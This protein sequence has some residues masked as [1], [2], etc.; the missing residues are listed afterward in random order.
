MQVNICSA[1]GLPAGPYCPSGSI[2]SG[3]Y[4]LGGSAGT[5]DEPYEI[6]QDLLNQTCTV[7]TS[8]TTAQNYE[9]QGE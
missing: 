6:S 2:T 9:T 7:H 8:I 5:Q 4:I 1:S 3:I